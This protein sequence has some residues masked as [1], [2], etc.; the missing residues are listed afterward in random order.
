MLD[1]DWVASFVDQ[2]MLAVD[3]GCSGLEGSEPTSC[4][5]YIQAF[6]EHPV[7][8]CNGQPHVKP[9]GG[10]ASIM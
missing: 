1:V 7:W 3:F 8:M 9:G 10:H 6:T 5:P 4:R 2:N